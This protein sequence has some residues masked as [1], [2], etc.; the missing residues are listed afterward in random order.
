M[1]LRHHHIHGQIESER[2]IA[3]VASAQNRGMVHEI[4]L[5]TIGKTRGAERVEK[6]GVQQISTVVHE[7][8]HKL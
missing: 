5:Q 8:L 2:H 7:V 3:G 6:E 4:L 1:V